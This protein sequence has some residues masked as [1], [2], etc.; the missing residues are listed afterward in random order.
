MK[1]SRLRSQSDLCY[2]FT[3]FLRVLCTVNFSREWAQYPS[4]VAEEPVD[5]FRLKYSWDDFNDIE[6]TDLNIVWSGEIDVESSYAIIYLTVDSGWS[7]VN[8]SVEGELIQADSNCSPC[9]VPLQPA[10][11]G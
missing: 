9:I 11:S 3:E 7:S 1:Y 10:V 8:I 4:K 5:V 2:G 6:S